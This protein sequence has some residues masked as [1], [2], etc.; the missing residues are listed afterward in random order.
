MI[1]QGA[2]DPKGAEKRG[3]DSRDE[4]DGGGDI[5]QDMSDSSEKM[6]GDGSN[7][8]IRM[9]EKFDRGYVMN[10][11]GGEGEIQKGDDD[12]S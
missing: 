7:S 11:D 8:R 3:T 1:G 12:Q 6:S 2:G 4:S 10:N 5:D 9:S